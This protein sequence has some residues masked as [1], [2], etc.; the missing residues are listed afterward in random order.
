MQFATPFIADKI[1][2]KVRVNFL[3][4]MMTLLMVLLPFCVI[5]FDQAT[6]FWLSFTILLLFPFFNGVI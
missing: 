4:G 1:T 3:F 2:Y 5:Y 6:K